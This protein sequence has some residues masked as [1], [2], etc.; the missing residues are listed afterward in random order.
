MIQRQL[1]TVLALALAAIAAFGAAAPASAGHVG[2]SIGATIPVGPGVVSLVVGQ[3][4]Y[5][6]GHPYPVY[7]RA[8]EAQPFYY[9]VAGPIHYHGGHHA[10]CYDH[11]GYGYHHPSCPA[12][13]G[14]F[15]A[16]NVHPGGY[17][18]YSSWSPN[19]TQYGWQG[20]RAPRN[21]GT[22][23]YRTYDGR[24]GSRYDSR[25]NDRRFNDRRYRDERYRG[26][27]RYDRDDRSDRVDRNRNWR[28]R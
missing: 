28:E 5:G 8:W 3:P 4:A 6:Y 7:G 21:Y 27:R 18:P 11:G 20:Y 9:R 17:W 1:P 19:W 24:Y 22:Y 12:L 14:Y 26:E 25:S 2:F 15:S 16:Y 10:N 13:H 23:G